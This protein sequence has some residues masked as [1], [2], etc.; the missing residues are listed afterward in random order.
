MYMCK[1][2]DGT[3]YEETFNIGIV[4]TVIDSQIN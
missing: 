4:Q 3:R 1:L 2:L